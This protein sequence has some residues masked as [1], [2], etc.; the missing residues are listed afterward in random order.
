LHWILFGCCLHH[1]NESQAN[2]FKPECST[3]GCKVAVSYYNSI[4]ICPWFDKVIQ[5]IAP[6]Q[7][8]IIVERSKRKNALSG[9]S[10]SFHENLKQK[11]AD[12]DEN[13]R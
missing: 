5:N 2:R 1:A 11:E 8:A 10:Y 7:V 12:N 4:S 3:N 13:L 9:E 6:V